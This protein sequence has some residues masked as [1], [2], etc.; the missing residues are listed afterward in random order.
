MDALTV[1]VLS[2]VVVAATTFGAA[3]FLLRR[4]P[5]IDPERLES[6][7]AGVR[8][9]SILR[10]ESELASQ[11][12]RLAARLGMA[13]GPG[14]HNRRLQYRM[15]LV[16][17]GFQDPRA[18]TIL[19]GAKVGLALV[20]LV[21]YPLYGSM[22]ARVLPNLFT[23]SATLGC[24]GFFLPDFWLR[25]RLQ[26]RKR[27]IVEAFPD[28]LDLLMVCVEAG[29]GFDAAV[30]RI[31]ASDHTGRSPLH[32]ELTRMHLEIRA[33]R[34]REEAMR[35]LGERTGCPEVKRVVGAFTQAER[36]GTPL[37]RT[38]RVHAEAARVDRRHRAE[39]KAYLAPLKMIFPTALFLLPAFILIALAPAVL[40][41]G[42]IFSSIGGAR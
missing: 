12:Q 35:D 9:S 33:G 27:R 25:R 23:I 29:M 34:P 18:V 15:K 26:T 10:F 11:W 24:L 36:L 21:V 20:G 1:A 22:V 3:F 17:A 14:D 6:R 4:W 5:A 19:M 30:A 7:G 8:T 38:L 37:G 40:T 39:A 16:Q 42:K 28:V 32:Q 41:L 13:L 2:F 31:A